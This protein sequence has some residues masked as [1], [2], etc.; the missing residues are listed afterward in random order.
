VTLAIYCFFASRRAKKEFTMKGMQLI[1]GIWVL[2]ELFLGNRKCFL[3]NHYQR[4]AG[5]S[6]VN[7]L[8]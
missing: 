4:V 7:L 1:G 5:E 2:R 3:K 6:D 8:T